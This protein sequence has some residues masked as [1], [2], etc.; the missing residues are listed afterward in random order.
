VH[1]WIYGLSDGLIRDLNISTSN[2][3]EL[4]TSYSKAIAVCAA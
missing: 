3:D 2:Q 4:A 1:G